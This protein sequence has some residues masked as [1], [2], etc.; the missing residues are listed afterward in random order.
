MKLVIF[1]II[2]CLTF[3]GVCMAENGNIELFKD[4]K[5]VDR[6][7]LS[8]KQKECMDAIIRDRRIVKEDWRK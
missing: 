5:V 7:E 6:N 3:G 4:Y 1:I 2:A 8:D